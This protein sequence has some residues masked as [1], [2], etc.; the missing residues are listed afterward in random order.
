MTPEDRYVDSRLAGDANPYTGEAVY[1]GEDD[2]TGWR[3]MQDDYES[4]MWRGFGE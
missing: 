3:D 1:R 2:G 4:A